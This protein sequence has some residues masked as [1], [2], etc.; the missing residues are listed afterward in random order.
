MNWQIFLFFI[1]ISLKTTLTLAASLQEQQAQPL[2][3]KKATLKNIADTPK[4]A[5]RKT[6]TTL[7]NLP[8]TPDQKDLLT[9]NIDTHLPSP[10]KV[11]NSLN[12][13]YKEDKTIPS[14]QEINKKAIDDLINS[15]S[16]TLM[17]LNHQ[18]RNLNTLTSAKSPR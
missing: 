17:R 2:E 12:A 5:Q 3:T 15:R 8:K 9:I 6:P 13:Y 11:Q 1:C 10:G 14:G 4:P 7:S 16:Q 18:D